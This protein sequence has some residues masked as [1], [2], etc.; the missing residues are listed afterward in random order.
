MNQTIEKIKES[1]DF[2]DFFRPRDDNADFVD[3]TY[4]L[5]RDGTFIFSEGYYHS[6]E[7][8]LPERKL[9]SHI[10]FVPLDRRRGAPDY[11]HK[12]IF[13]QDYENITKEIMSTQP[14]DR[15]YPCQLQR[16]QEIDPGQ[17]EIPRTVWNRYKSLVP[18]QEL[19]GCFP[20]RASLQAIMKR[21]G[22]DPAAAKVKT[23][24][25]HTAELL[26]VELS[27]L[28][29]SGSLSLGTYLNP[30][31][32]DFVIFGTAGEVKR[33][34]NFMYRLT[35]TDDRRKVFEFGKYWPIRFWDQAG[36]ERFM[37]CPFFS[38]LDPEE[39]PL[40]NF[41]CVE[42]GEA[43]LEGEIVDHTHNAF[44]PSVLMVE[45]CRL[46]QRPY[47]HITRLIFYHGG[48]RGDWREG[49]RFRAKGNHVR[50]TAYSL[51][52]GRREKKEEFEALLVNNLDQVI[53][54][55]ENK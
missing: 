49:Y 5:R 38:Y 24:A 3:A 30:H 27:R 14:L 55:K 33:I 45:G 1:P 7:N 18:L 13:G 36:K 6:R 35:D 20:A 54:L 53:R 28:G 19:I 15:F 37:V 34:V 26:E 23:I 44:N 10:V 39:A 22:Q 32:L 41:D 16:Y 12:K 51:R 42:L 8:P 31:D 11:A 9:V 47:P 46:N 25:E 29:I 43:V 48:E 2:P 52:N 4:F 17:K 50:I 21:G 40:R